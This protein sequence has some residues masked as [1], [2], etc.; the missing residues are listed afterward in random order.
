[1]TY[2]K[3]FIAFITV[4]LESLCNAQNGFTLAD[5]ICVI[6]PQEDPILLSDVNARQKQKNISKKE[7]LD[8]MKREAGL[9]LYAKNQ[10]KFNIE[11]IK[12]A[13]IN[14][15][16]NIKKQNNLSDKKFNKLLSQAPYYTNEIKF[17]K[18]TE[19]IMVKNQ[20]MAFLDSQINIGADKL[21][22]AVKQQQYNVDN[23]VIFITLNKKNQNLNILKEIALRISYLIKSKKSLNEI[24]NIYKNDSRV[25]FSEPMDY[26][27]GILKPDYEKALE[28]NASFPVT[29]L[30]DDGEALVMIWKI[31]KK[32]ENKELDRTALENLEKQLKD[33]AIDDKLLEN[34]NL[35]SL[36]TINDCGEIP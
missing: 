26:E 16:N 4:F 1:M 14:H 15:V 11:N 33:K 30:L 8:E 12:M 22:E 19:Y 36:K 29:E 35:S 31:K 2:L 27:K 24:K 28:K 34:S 17:I 21:T 5:Q 3:F 25:L 20:V 7:A 23:Q 18:Q 10:L 6:V 13:A 9:F 32:R